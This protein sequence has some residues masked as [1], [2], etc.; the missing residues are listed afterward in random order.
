MAPLYQLSY[1]YLLYYVWNGWPSDTRK[2]PTD[3]TAAVCHLG[4]DE[5]LT[6]TAK[7][8]IFFIRPNDSGVYSDVF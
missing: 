3:Q 8:T 4:L 1:V 7:V 2:G 5:N 6:V